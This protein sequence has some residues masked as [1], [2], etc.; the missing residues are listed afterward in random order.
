MKRLDVSNE[1]L[2]VLSEKVSDFSA[3]NCLDRFTYYALAKCELLS[4][5]IHLNSE[6]MSKQIFVKLSEKLFVCRFIMS[7]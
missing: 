6:L 1:Y 4:E 3:Q 2:Y 7:R 5:E